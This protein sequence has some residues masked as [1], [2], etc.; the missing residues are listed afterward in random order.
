MTL[1][2]PFIHSWSNF[3]SRPHREQLTASQDRDS[4]IEAPKWS[5][6]AFMMYSLSPHYYYSINNTPTVTGATIVP[7]EKFGEPWKK[8]VVIL[9]GY[10]DHF[11]FA[12]SRRCKAKLR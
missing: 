3:T 1:L 5:L 6:I 2:P 9:V 12:L 4:P 11:P 8:T 7:Y 10:K